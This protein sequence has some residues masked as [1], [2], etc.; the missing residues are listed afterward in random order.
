MPTS[1]LKLFYNNT[2]VMKNLQ[3]RTKEFEEEIT[4]QKKRAITVEIYKSENIFY[5]F[6]ITS[7]FIL[8]KHI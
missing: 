7:L 1:S 8:S 2:D 6:V 5:R 4:I 3:N